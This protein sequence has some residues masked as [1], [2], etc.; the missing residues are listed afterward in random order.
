MVNKWIELVK[1]LLELPMVVGYILFKSCVAP[2]LW[3]MILVGMLIFGYI[4]ITG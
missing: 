4:V 2:M 1:D 3:G